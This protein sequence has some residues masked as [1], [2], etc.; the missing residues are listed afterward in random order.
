MKV[1]ITLHTT[2]LSLGSNIPDR[3]ANLR[4][5][6][7]CIT[8]SVGTVTKQSPIYETQSWGYSDGNYLNQTIAVETALAPLQLLTT[9]NAI[10]SA[11]GR[12]RSGKGYEARTIDIDIL[13]YDNEILDTPQLVIPHPKIA[14]RRFVLQPTADIAPDFVH[15]RI[16]KTIRQLLEECEDT[17]QC[18]MHNS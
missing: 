15:P 4:R 13:F 2:Y 9:I 16:G 18:A 7:N 3:A 14:L 12:V 6:V 5:A 8:E 1:K 10:E 17:G 11:L